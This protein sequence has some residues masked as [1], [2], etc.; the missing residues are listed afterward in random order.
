[1]GV[2]A[3]ER[4][5]LLAALFVVGLT[6]PARAAD[7]AHA[8]VAGGC[9]WC[10]ES[11]FDKVPGVLETVSG[12][13]GGRTD[14]PTYKTHS[15]DGHLEVVRIAYNPAVIGYRQLLDIFWR[16]VDVTD[17]GGQ[18]CDRGNSYRTA[19]FVASEEERAIAE[20]SRAAAQG[21]LGHDIK[22]RIL[23]AAPFWPAED[24]HQDYYQ[25]NPIRYNF[26]RYACGR[27]SRIEEVWGDQA[28]T[29]LTG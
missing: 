5:V 12:Y 4:T 2:G 20:A 15:A 21:S 29:G 26:Y 11:D 18:F 17:D 23:N 16:T 6:W 25:K 14:N 7:V 1:M 24:Y 22:T 28:H 19:V 10:V 3:W 9:F 8:V 27:D 13:A